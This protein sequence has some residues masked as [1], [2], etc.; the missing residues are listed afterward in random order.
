MECRCCGKLT[1]EQFC[2]DDCFSMSTYR[3]ESFGLLRSM[4]LYEDK[5]VATRYIPEWQCNVDITNDF[6]NDDKWHG[7]SDMQTLPEF[8]H[9]VRR[10]Q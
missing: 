5:T 3:R 1:S 6:N 8:Y 4:S 9:L 10:T 7:I 2:G